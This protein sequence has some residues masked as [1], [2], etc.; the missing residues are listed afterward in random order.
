[1]I[2]QTGNSDDPIDGLVHLAWI[3]APRLG[4][5]QRVEEPFAFDAREHVREKIIGKKCTFIVQYTVG[6]RRYLTVEV[7]KVDVALQLVQAGLAKVQEK[8]VG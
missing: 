2:R 1:M 6:G 5:S 8:R 7:D 3:S 4:S